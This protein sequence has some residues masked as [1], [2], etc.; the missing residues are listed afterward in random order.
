MDEWLK[1]KL[2]DMDL[3]ESVYLPFIKTIL[4]DD[5][6]DNEAKGAEIKDYI[7][8]LPNIVRILMI[9]D[10]VWISIKHDTTTAK[11]PSFIF[12]IMLIIQQYSGGICEQRARSVA[13]S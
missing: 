8:D 13:I 7:G 5:S 6:M 9:E 10:L 11:Q 1:S 2:I 12:E 4:E 3:D